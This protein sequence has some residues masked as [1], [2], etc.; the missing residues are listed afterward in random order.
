[1]SK[2]YLITGIDDELFKNFKTVCAYLGTSMKDALIVYMMRSV[3]DFDFT[4]L[5]ENK[6]KIEPDDL[7]K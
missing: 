2:A 5:S 6:I 3:K 4:K 1:M 7:F